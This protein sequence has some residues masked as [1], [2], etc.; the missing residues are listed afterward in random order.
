MARRLLTILSALSLLVF[1]AI[2]AL[3]VRSYSRP[4]GLLWQSHY[5]RW[6]DHGRLR[7]Y[8]SLIEGQMHIATARRT[9]WTKP[10]KTAIR[11]S[12]ID[13]ARREDEMGQYRTFR[14]YELPPPS[15]TPDRKLSRSFSLPWL[16]INHRRWTVPSPKEFY[17][18]T[19]MDATLTTFPAPLAACAFAALPTSYA[20]RWLTLRRARP[21]LCPSCNYDLSA[22]PD[23]CPECGTAVVPSQSAK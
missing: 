21:G 9:P 7:V 19:P 15:P 20:V 6:R 11:D 14:R 4:D 10:T 23:R 22:T 8:L 13:S 17:I 16:G 1:L 5:T 18:Y 2:V 12:E 3:W